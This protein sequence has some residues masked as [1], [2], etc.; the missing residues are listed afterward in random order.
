MAGARKRDEGCC[1]IM[2]EE[3]DKEYMVQCDAC[4]EWCHYDCEGS[5]S[6]PM[7]S[8]GTPPEIRID[9]KSTDMHQ[10]SGG[11]PINIS[12]S[13]HVAAAAW[14][15]LSGFDIMSQY[16]ANNVCQ[17]S[18][19]ILTT[20]A[21][22][23]TSACQET[24]RSGINWDDELT[25]E[26]AKVALLEGKLRSNNMPESSGTLLYSFKNY[27]R[28]SISIIIVMAKSKVAPLKPISIPRLELQA[29]VL[30]DDNQYHGKISGNK[31]MPIS[32]CHW[33]SDSKTVLQWLR[34]DSRKLQQCVMHRVSEIQEASNIQNWRCIPSKMNPADFVTK[35]NKNENR[36][37]VLVN[38]PGKWPQCS[39]LIL[40][41][42][43]K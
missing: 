41:M 28:N 25:T 30:G 17:G 39:N 13:P 35:N 37:R 26:L 29:A 1:C 16:E 12:T 36:V 34:M 40:L 38:G 9:P 19:G 20:Y 4:D 14:T 18:T 43:K 3:V 27:T 5:A 32:S 6:P 7:A 22:A 11:P 8:Y 2:C 24:W 10:R 33:W 31:C 15:G 42:W 23:T 21:T